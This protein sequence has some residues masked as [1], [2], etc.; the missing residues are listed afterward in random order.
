MT[1]SNALMGVILGAFLLT[2]LR[3]AYFFHVDEKRNRIEKTNKPVK[4]PFALA[5]CT[6]TTSLLVGF[7]MINLIYF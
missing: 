3:V 7:G 6:F 1:L 5:Y 4:A 2:L